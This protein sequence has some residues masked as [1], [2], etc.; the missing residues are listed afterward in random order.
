MH[1]IDLM[2]ITGLPLVEPGDDLAALVADAIWA[3]G[4]SIE[5][6]DIFVFA[7]KVVSKAEGR[8]A[9]LSDFV[10]STEARDLAA[11]TGKDPR[12]VE[13]ILSESQEVIRTGAQLLIVAHKLGFVMANAGIDESNIAQTGDGHRV[14]LLPQDPDASAAALRLRF[15]ELF[16]VDVGVVIA[17]SFGRPWRNGVVGVA[18]GAAGVPAVMDKVG[19]PDLFG[20]PMRV[21]EIATAD[22]LAS[23]AALLMGEADEGLPVVI[24][25]GF[26]GQGPDRP[27][28]ALVR[29]KGR[30]LFR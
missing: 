6:G 14:L 18:I 8:Y 19:A 1:S 22:Q 11:R 7:Q 20:R 27:A 21:T 28:S 25:R 5:H 9:R 13:A 30:D 3:Q 23:A 29:A 10:P 16:D 17:D 12:L 26:R 15:A 24:I 2:A 4:R